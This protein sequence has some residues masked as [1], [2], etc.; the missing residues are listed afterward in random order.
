[1]METELPATYFDGRTSRALPVTLHWHAA[2]GTLDIRGPTTELRYARRDV[3]VESR[4]G[5]GPR[6]IRFADGA[7][8]EVTDNDALD[9][10]L[11][12]WAPNPAGAWLHRLETS[13]P[14]VLV[15]CVLLVACGWA[16]LHFGLPWGARKVAFLLPAGLTRTLGDQT[17]ATLDRTMLARTELTH[18][19][20]LA[21]RAEFTRFLAAAGIAAPH[22]IEFR[23]MRAGGANAFA[24]PSGTIVL[25]DELVF[26]A[27]DDREIVAVL[28][29]ECGHVAHR[30]ALRAVLQN[31]AVFVVLALVTGDA[32]S[33]TAFSGA[34]PAF[35]LQNRF[36]R[37]FEREADT[38][39]VDTL[40]R[41]GLDPAHLAT[42][43]ER[44]TKGHGVTDSKA[45]NY[46]STHP[47]T[48]ERIEAITGKK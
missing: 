41:G 8:C 29:H 16:A 26:L 33:A 3:T 6:F 28:A 27:A 4:L 45:L 23:A 31:S 24:L 43:L 1:M 10:I 17:L 46:L 35:L 13:W 30:H 15:A 44:L 39:A 48:P 12:T 37:E 18:E 36:S 11:A 40:R 38:Y 25:T 19:R 21:L 2:D 5:R 32:S 22:A 7:R 42:M 47:P 20:Q 14:Q 9:A 34:L